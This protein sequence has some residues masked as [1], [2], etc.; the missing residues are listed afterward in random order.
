MPQDPMPSL[1]TNIQTLPEGFVVDN[2]K[3]QLG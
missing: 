1:N 2:E 3:D